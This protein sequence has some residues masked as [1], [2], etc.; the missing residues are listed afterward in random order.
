M[1]NMIATKQSVILSKSIWPVVCTLLFTSIVTSY[2]FAGEDRFA[3]P[4]LDSSLD[5]FDERFTSNSTNIDFI[6]AQVLNNARQIERAGDTLRQNALLFRN[7]D[8][9]SG[10]Y[11]ATSGSVIIPPG[12]SANTI[13][14]INQNDGDSYA[15]QR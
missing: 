8:D 12:T 11:G 7:E 15:I 2:A 3:P 9:S 14:I 1:K 10:G 5:N 4:T 6:V 13:I